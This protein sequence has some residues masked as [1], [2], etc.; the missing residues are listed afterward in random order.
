M[1]RSM[2]DTPRCRGWG[3]RELRCQGGRTCERAESNEDRGV[4]SPGDGRPGPVSVHES[5]L[6]RMRG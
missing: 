2:C 1:G 6:M 3:P 4:E 5:V